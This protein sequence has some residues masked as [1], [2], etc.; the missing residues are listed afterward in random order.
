MRRVR[1]AKPEDAEL[2]SD[3]FM[4]P[5]RKGSTPT[6]DP[7]D[8]PGPDEIRGLLGRVHEQ[9]LEELLTLTECD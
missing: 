4:L 7:Y 3:E 2:I 9:T 1:G 8:Y 5:F 6:A